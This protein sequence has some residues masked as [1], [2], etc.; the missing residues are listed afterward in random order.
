MCKSGGGGCANWSGTPYGC[1]LGQ[2]S[3]YSSQSNCVEMGC[4]CEGYDPNQSVCD[5]QADFNQALQAGIK[6]NKQQ[7]VKQA[8]VWMWVYLIAYFI[9]FVWAI[10]LAL[11]VAPGAE[12]T[13][14]VVFAVVFGPIYVLSYYL[15]LLKQ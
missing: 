10:I 9:F 7:A 14:H 4:N 2:P 11:Q 1:T 13:E 6:Y 3:C 5:N 15:G 12:R 8:G